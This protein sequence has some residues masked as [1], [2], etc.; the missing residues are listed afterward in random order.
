MSFDSEEARLV[1][2]IQATAFYQAKLAGANFITRQWVAKKL[3]RSEDWVTK[4]WTKN[5]MDCFGD[6]SKCGRPES[7]SQES[8]DIIKSGIGLQRKSCRALSGEILA[9]RQKVHHAES[10]GL[11]L[12]GFRFFLIK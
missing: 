7:L 4:N 11:V 8:K 9:K 6:F 10:V 1:D 2:R 12:V 5:P 3:K